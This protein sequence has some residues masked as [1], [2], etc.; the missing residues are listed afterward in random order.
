[1]L[2]LVCSPSPPP[3]PLP[4]PYF[5]RDLSFRNENGKSISQREALAYQIPF[6]YQGEKYFLVEDRMFEL[7]KKYNDP[8][9][10]ES[11]E[12]VFSGDYAVV[13]ERP[14]EEDHGAAGHLRTNVLAG[15]VARRTEE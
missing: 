10:E 3:L 11:I 9:F 5:L 8:R 4:L 6:S 12:K 14:W 15:I 2:S 13:A 7:V 1:M